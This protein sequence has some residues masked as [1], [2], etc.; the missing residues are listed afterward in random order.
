MKKINDKTSFF[1]LL[2]ILIAGYSSL[3]LELVAI[4]QVIPYL[5]NDTIITSIIIGVILIFLALGYWRAGKINIRKI[6]IRQKIINNF[7]IS[8]VFLFVGTTYLFFNY[9]FLVLKF[10]GI[11]SRVL[12]AFAFSFIFLSIPSYLLAQTTPLVAMYFTK[13]SSPSMMGKI[14]AFGTI[15]SFAGSI[16]TTLIIMPL[17]GANYAVMLNIFVTVLGIIILNKKDNV[18]IYI[19]CFI[20]LVVT[21]LFNSTNMQRKLGIIS[22]NGFS[23]IKVISV[24]DDQ[25][26]LMLINNSYSSK[27]SKVDEL[28][29]EYAKYV[30]NNFIYTIPKEEK[31]DILV[32]GAGGFTLG[33]KDDYNNYTFIDV[34]ESLLDVSEKYFLEE[35]LPPNKQFVKLPAR[36]F[37]KNNNQKYDLIVLDTFTNTVSMPASLITVE[38]FT[39]VKR[40]LKDNGIV[41]MN[42]VLS[43]N[44]ND[45]LSVRF[46]NTVDHVFKNTTRH[47]IGNINPWLREKDNRLN[48]ILYIYY[49]IPTDNSI[50][51]DNN[52]SSM[53]DK[54]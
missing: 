1:L 7:I 45:K 48:N 22:N 13:N 9:Y 40:K 28:M 2:I 23:T 53:F 8:T 42:T 16:V 52:N 50:Y 38:Y 3:A 34:D 29:F 44:F 5:D 32:I 14:L 47:V 4:R 35:K 24:D 25:S 19:T 36:A 37:L 30:N 54:N 31:K 10:L 49:N 27:I 21:F 20:F 39:D 46:D 41:I 18:N 15:G 43:P 17:L 33:L 12:Q 51:T 6:S 26:K 11:Q